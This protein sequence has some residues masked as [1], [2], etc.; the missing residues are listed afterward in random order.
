MKEATPLTIADGLGSPIGINTWEIVRNLH[1]VQE[2]F[3]VSETQISLASVEILERHGLVVEPSAAVPLACIFY[4]NI[5]LEHIRQQAAP[6]SIDVIITGGN[7]TKVS[8][9][10]LIN[11]SEPP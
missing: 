9:A 5:F 11:I 1:Y 8:L 2:S 6:Q 7:T 3:T 10:Q 4:S